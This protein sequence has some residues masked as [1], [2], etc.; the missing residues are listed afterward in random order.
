MKNVLAHFIS[1]SYEETSAARAHISAIQ[2]KIFNSIIIIKLLILNKKLKLCNNKF[3]NT[4]DNLLL[5][6]NNY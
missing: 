6:F 1:L 3:V 5:Q 4:N 2:V